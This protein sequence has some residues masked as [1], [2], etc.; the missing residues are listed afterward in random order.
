VV[1]GTSGKGPEPEPDLILSPTEPDVL[2]REGHPRG[3]RAEW[4]G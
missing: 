2:D 1:E 3:N 4:K